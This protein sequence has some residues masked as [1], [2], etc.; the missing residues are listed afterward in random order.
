MN[1]PKVSTKI[2]QSGISGEC[3]MCRT[4]I[5]VECMETNC[6]NCFYNRIGCDAVCPKCLPIF[7]FY[8]GINVF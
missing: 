4:T 7:K 1:Y 3:S 5:W 6:K 2:L 8:K